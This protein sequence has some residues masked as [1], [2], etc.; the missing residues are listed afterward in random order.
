MK[1]IITGII[2]L[3]L[4]LFGSSQ[5]KDSI[6]LGYKEFLTVV[7][8]NHPVVKQARLMEEQ[9]EAAV[10]EARG[11]F[12]P[13]IESTL[14]QKDYK[15][16]EYYNLF[17]ST[18]KVPTWYGVELKAQFE[19]NDGV[20]LNPQNMVPEDG[21]F[22][23]GISVPV[24]QDLFMNER[25]A[26]LKKAKAY[27]QQTRAEQELAVNQILYEASRA[28]FDWYYSYQELSL[29]H[30]FI[31]NAEIRY[32]GIKKS[33]QAGDKSA[34][35]T[36]EANIQ[37]QD[38]T[39][40]LEQASLE[41]YKSTLKLSTF[42]WADQNTPLELQEAVYPVSESLEEIHNS[43]I[44]LKEALKD[45][46]KLLS[47][48][49]KVEI[50]EYE[51]RLKANKLLPRL[52][53]EYNFLSNDSAIFNSYD[54]DNYKFGFNFSLPIF[55]RKE[56]GALEASKLKL[57]SAEL[58]LLNERLELKNKIK[59]LQE[60]LVSYQRQAIKA[61]ELVE[62]YTIMFNAEER[63]LELGESSVFLVN[64]REKSLITAKLKFIS[65]QQKLWNTYAELKSVLAQFDIE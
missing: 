27:R 38:R 39:L 12:D 54:Y 52:D 64:S 44:L 10:L 63:K 17:N 37:I 8:M 43:E 51:K 32:S 5:E 26:A 36:L 41:F 42:L 31:E 2:V 55:L 48:S 34:I 25:M 62:S 19:R 14:A 35:D 20:Y 16:I 4:P 33:H 24:G 13:K 9:G 57:Q 28:Y 1:V 3:L 11:G 22:S 61:G 58:D 30:D 56:R 65:I 21:L 60:Q 18:F 29:Y 15:G 7:K 23:A 59:A 47:L 46:P 50:L 53:L 40:S 45:H 6:F 49:S